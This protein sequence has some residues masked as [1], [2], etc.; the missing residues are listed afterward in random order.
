[1]RG[2][3]SSVGGGRNSLEES[4]EAESSWKVCECMWEDWRML[5]TLLE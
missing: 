2:Y 5:D 4:K 3:N 1:V